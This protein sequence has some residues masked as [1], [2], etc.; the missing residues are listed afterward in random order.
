MIS[1]KALSAALSLSILST[2]LVAT[3]TADGL[4]AI[5]D[6]DKGTFT[7][8]LY[9]QKAPLSSANFVGLA[10]GT[11]PHYESGSTNPV[12]SNFYD[13]LT[14]HRAVPSF[15]I[16]G[17]DPEGDGTGGPGYDWPDEVHPDLIHDAEGILSMANSGAN[18]NGSQFFVTLDATPNLDGIHNVF[19]KVVEGIAVVRA[20]GILPNAGSNNNNSLNTPVVI[21]SVDILR[22][23]EAAEAFDPTL[24]AN[25]FD[26]SIP[27]FGKEVQS[28]IQI[29]NTSSEKITVSTPYVPLNEYSVF[30]SDDL[31]T[32][33]EVQH[34]LPSI[35]S[36]AADPAVDLMP[37]NGPEFV[38]FDTTRRIVS[39]MSGIID[40]IRIESPDGQN[41]FVEVI[42]IEPSLVGTYNAND[43][44]DFGVY[45]D[46]IEISE[47]RTQLRVQFP[48]NNPYQPISNAIQFYLDRSEGNEGNVYIRDENSS[49]S[50]AGDD[51]VI[52]G[53]FTITPAD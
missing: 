19:G 45:L 37:V 51:I 4:Y 33:T 43:S 18:T 32:W 34:V 10:E 38:R 20:I 8:Q 22:I 7:T 46:W 52:E 13:G 41:T 14:F 25:H 16:Q 47:T 42:K 35:D 44:T 11:L 12:Y 17:G 24:Y 27:L 26:P 53:T 29:A 6:T 9:F 2:G 30:T 50:F 15:V 31:D 21:N 1:K 28:E 5:F 40:E 49:L 39:D 48:S 23:G 3:P 36:D